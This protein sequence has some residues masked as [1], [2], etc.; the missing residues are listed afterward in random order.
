[1]RTPPPRDGIISADN[2]MRALSVFSAL[3]LAVD[4]G[5][6]HFTASS[7]RDICYV[8]TT[9]HNGRSTR[10]LRRYYTNYIYAFAMI[11]ARFDII[12]T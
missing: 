1:M 2:T 10:H 9:P 4:R 6:R 7:L 5:A 12:L 3:M 8:A 11:D